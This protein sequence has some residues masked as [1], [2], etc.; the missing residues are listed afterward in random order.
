MGVCSQHHCFVVGLLVDGVSKSYAVCVHACLLPPFVGSS[1]QMAL[2]GGSWRPDARKVP[3]S[4]TREIGV[5]QLAEVGGHAPLLIPILLGGPSV[6]QGF[7]PL[8][9]GGG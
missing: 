1:P 7:L 4:A 2:G 8:L 5:V 6:L 3:L 9:E